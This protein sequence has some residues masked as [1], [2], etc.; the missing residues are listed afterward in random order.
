MKDLDSREGLSCGTVNA[1]KRGEN[2]CLQKY[3]YKSVSIKMR[4]EQK[5]FFLKSNGDLILIE[6]SFR[7]DLDPGAMSFIPEGGRRQIAQHCD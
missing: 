6:F 1:K 7:E 2:E 4:G 3:A 5:G